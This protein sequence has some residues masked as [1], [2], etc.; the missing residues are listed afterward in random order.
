MC[1]AICSQDFQ[2]W[3]KWLVFDAV[4]TLLITVL[5]K[6]AEFTRPL[7]TLIGWL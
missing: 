3:L 6:R 5:V 7:F 4:F 2:P 1:A